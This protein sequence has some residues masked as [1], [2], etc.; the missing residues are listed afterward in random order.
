MSDEKLKSRIEI[1]PRKD[2][3]F[4]L[5]CIY[6]NGDVF[7]RKTYVSEKTANRRGQDWLEKD[8]QD[9]LQNSGFES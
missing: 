8:Q 9:R 1:I 2:G 6:F 5:Y 3:K 4:D 7:S